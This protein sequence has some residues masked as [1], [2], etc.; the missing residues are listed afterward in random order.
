MV[1][2]EDLDFARI[3]DIARPYLGE[4]VGVYGD[5]TPLDGRETPVSGR[6]RPRRPVAIQKH[7]RRLTRRSGRDWSAFRAFARPGLRVSDEI[8]EELGGRMI[9]EASQAGAIVV[10]DEGVEIGVAL[11]VV[12]E[13]AVMGGAVLRHAVEMLAKAAVEALDHAVGLRPERAGEAV[14]NDV[15]AQSAVEG[16]LTGGLV[17]RFGLFVDGKAVGEFG[18][19]VGQDGVDGEREAARKRPRKPAAVSA[20]RSG[21]ISR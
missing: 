7:P 21:R 17:V 15:L 2:P 16:M 5:W 13:A 8:G 10:G 3:L 19:V 11:G 18:A 12:V 6:P 1:E 9:V 4:V 20:R 14:G